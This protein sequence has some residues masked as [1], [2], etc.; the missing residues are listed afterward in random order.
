VN[1]GSDMFPGEPGLSDSDKDALIEF[2]K[3]F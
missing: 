2:L 1:F 3:T